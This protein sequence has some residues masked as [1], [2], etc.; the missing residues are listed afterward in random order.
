MQLLLRERPGD[1]LSSE[2]ETGSLRLRGGAVARG[3]RRRRLFF[4]G[5]AREWERGGDAWRS[6]A[7]EL[8]RG[9]PELSRPSDF[10][11]LR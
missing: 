4:S 1:P 8:S 11:S 2:L 3:A 7:L 10:S 5:G 9:F 6:G